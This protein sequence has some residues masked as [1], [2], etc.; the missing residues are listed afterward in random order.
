MSAL[1]AGRT[2]HSCEIDREGQRRS[3]EPISKR[4]RRRRA[5][6]AHGFHTQDRRST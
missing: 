4:D 6:H 3:N 2:S 5:A 1:I